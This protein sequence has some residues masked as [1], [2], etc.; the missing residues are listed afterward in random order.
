MKKDFSKSWKSSIQP[1]KQRKY[2]ANAPLHIRN[3]FIS[4]HLSKDLI[5]KHSKRNVRA[6]IGDKVKIMRGQFKGKTG[7]IERVNTK[8]SKVFVSGMDFTKKDGSKAFYPI[9]PSNLL[10]TEL[11]LSDRRRFKKEGSKAKGPGQ[12]QKADK[13][14]A[15]KEIKPKGEKEEKKTVESKEAKKN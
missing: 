9:H 1:R 5:K 12:A 3:S 4:S 8:Y 10:I 13:L 6:R 11:N 7:K 14:A 15:K 2:T